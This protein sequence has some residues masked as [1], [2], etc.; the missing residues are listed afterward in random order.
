MRRVTIGGMEFASVPGASFVM[1]SGPGEGADDERPA[2]RVELSP[3]LLSVLPVTRQ[4]FAAPAGKGPCPDDGALPAAG[5]SWFDALDW[6]RAFGERHGVRARLPYEAEWECACRA[7]TDARFFWGDSADPAVAARH[8]RFAFNSGG[9][10][11]PA[12]A[13]EPNAWGLYD[14][15]GNV[16]EWCMDFYGEDWYAKSPGRDPRGPDTGAFRVI[17]GGC[18][19]SAVPVRCA[20]RTWNDPHARGPHEGFRVAVEV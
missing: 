8:G 9:R 4:A 18:Y 5:V 2:H 3:F 12:G 10:P 17:R 16:W 6:C 15:L 7:G 14:T 20:F 19:D 11:G 1:G 13:L